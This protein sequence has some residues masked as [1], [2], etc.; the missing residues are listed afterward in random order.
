LSSIQTAIS[1][2]RVGSIRRANPLKGHLQNTGFIHVWKLSWVPKGSSRIAVAAGRRGVG[3][4]K[5]VGHASDGLVAME[6]GPFKT[7]RS[8][9]R[10]AELLHFAIREIPRT[11][12]EGGHGYIKNCL[13]GRTRTLRGTGA[14][15]PES[16]L[17]TIARIQ[18]SELVEK[19]SRAQE[20]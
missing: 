1:R 8:G 11:I 2:R 10:A 20:H 12:S 13:D 16:Q 19:K 18:H 15:G 14:R 4:S 7:R 6:T 3:L 17:R 9:F 5:S